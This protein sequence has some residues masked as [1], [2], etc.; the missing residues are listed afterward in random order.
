MCEWRRGIC[1]QSVKVGLT[2][3]LAARS[4][5]ARGRNGGVRKKPL[6]TER[7]GLPIVPAMNGLTHFGICREIIR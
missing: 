5:P 2:G 7:M 4:G 3:A 1:N 6:L